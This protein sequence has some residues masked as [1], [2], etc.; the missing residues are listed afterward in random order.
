M[1]CSGTSRCIIPVTAF[2]P[3]SEVL[4]LMLLVD[5]FR[6][7]PDEVLSK[8]L[9]QIIAF[10]GT[11]KLTDGGETSAQLRE[12]LSCIPVEALSRWG[13]EAVRGKFEDSGFALQDIVNE[14]GRRLGFTVRP[15]T[16]R[17]GRGEPY[18]GLWESRTGH[19]LVVET[20]TSDNFTIDLKRLVEYRRRLPTS[21][22]LR[23][24]DSSILL[25]LGRQETGDYEDRIKGSRYAFGM[26]FI[27]VD[28][29]LRLLALKEAT[30]DELALAN[31]STEIF[32]LFTSPKFIGLD[33]VVK[34]VTVAP[35]LPISTDRE[36]RWPA[37]SK[38]GA[39]PAAEIDQKILRRV[40]NAMPQG[41]SSRDIRRGLGRV[42]YETFKQ[43][44]RSLMMGANPPLS[45]KNIGKKEWVYL[46]E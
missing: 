18:D 9:W 12:I 35:L 28:A 6:R 8:G 13:N 11:G 25:V 20:K 32:E 37:F 15:G 19:R 10:A 42:D 7:S 2:W 16:Y 23:E 5:L 44:M 46:N 29:L 39:P 40:R 38:R 33:P 41:I 4:N 43:R 1:L 34:L 31:L 14:I 17:G 45:V 3:N 36:A 24:E 21:K 30:A 27:T 22:W 26:R